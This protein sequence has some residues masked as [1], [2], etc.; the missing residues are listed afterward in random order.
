MM[1]NFIMFKYFCPLGVHKWSK[2]KTYKKTFQTSRDV[3]FYDVKYYKSNL[4]K[5]LFG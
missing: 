2:I 3:K 4:E 5:L 1:E